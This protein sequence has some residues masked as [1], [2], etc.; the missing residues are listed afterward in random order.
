MNNIFNLTKSHTI[1][2]DM[3]MRQILCKKVV[4]V[5]VKCPLLIIYTDERLYVDIFLQ[6]V[7]LSSH[8]SDHEST[9]LQN[10]M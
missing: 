6:K 4:I 10:H 5:H 9:R 1:R 2:T 7:V 3:T 8:G